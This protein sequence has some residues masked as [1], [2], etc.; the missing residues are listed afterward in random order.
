VQIEKTKEEIQEKRH[1]MQLLEDRIKTS[2]ASNPNAVPLEISQH[3]SNLTT[4]L[5]EKAFDLEVNTKKKNLVILFHNSLFFD[6]FHIV[7]SSPF[8]MYVFLSTQ[9][10]TVSTYTE[11]SILM[12]QSP[13]LS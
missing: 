7:S 6:R 13:Q 12:V 10:L 11:A 1:Q 4:Q 9:I 8:Q 5:N 2:D 3:I